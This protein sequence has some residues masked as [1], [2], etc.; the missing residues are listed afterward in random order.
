MVAPT[1]VQTA[2]DAAA[3]AAA[4]AAAEK[5]AAA[6]AAA[7]AAAAAG[8]DGLPPGTVGL[9]RVLSKDQLFEGPN[10]PPCNALCPA[11]YE[12]N[13]AALTEEGVRSLRG[14]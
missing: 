3:A 1:P 5:A 13:P 4:V 14:L 6:A 2:D 8:G 10:L 9:K 7:I 11:C 12:L